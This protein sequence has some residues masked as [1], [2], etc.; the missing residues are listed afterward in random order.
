ML[1]QDAFVLLDADY[2]PGRHIA[3]QVPTL[4]PSKLTF[5]VMIGTSTIYR[6]AH[7]GFSAFQESIVKTNQI[8]T[9]L[10][11]LSPA[12]DSGHGEACLEFGRNYPRS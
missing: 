4:C 6:H 12:L 8:A 11:T 1:A 7:V 9:G 3:S 2:V 5:G 10:P